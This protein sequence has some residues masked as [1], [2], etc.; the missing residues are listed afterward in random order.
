MNDKVLSLF[1]AVSDL[2]LFGCTAMPQTGLICSLT[3]VIGVAMKVSD[4]LSVYGQ[5][6]SR[7]DARWSILRSAS[8]IANPTRIGSVQR[9]KSQLRSH[10]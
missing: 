4:A 9:S 5:F 10:H 8:C 3:N 1:A 7:T 6:D 2:G